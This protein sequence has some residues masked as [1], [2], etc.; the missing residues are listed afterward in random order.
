MADESEPNTRAL[1]A[2]K[3]R[4]ALIAAAMELFAE[5]GLTGPSLDAICKKAG[6]TRGAF[7]VHFKAREDLIVAVVEEVMGGFIDAIVA[8]GDAGA[9]LA[10]IVQTFTL[11]VQV[12]HFPIP[13]RVRPHQILEAC[14]RS[15]VLRAKYLELLGRAR[16]RLAHAVERGQAEGVV[17]ADLDSQ[18]IAQLLL[19]VVLG[20]EVATELTVPFDAVTVGRNVVAMFSTAE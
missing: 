2:E 7:Y 15:P 17:R 20:V 13:G 14:A 6:F 3:T 5:E 18:A 10:T 11:A 8:G 1:A 19:A 9:D 16:E 4:R 12:G